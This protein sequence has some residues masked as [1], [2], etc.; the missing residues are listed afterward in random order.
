M[1]PKSKE[2]IHWPARE[3][4]NSIRH[5]PFDFSVSAAY[6]PWLPSCE[7][8]PPHLSPQVS[9][10]FYS[11]SFPTGRPRQLGSSTCTA[12]TGIIAAHSFDLSVCLSVCLSVFLSVCL[13]VCLSVYCMC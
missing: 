7:G 10:A 2:N 12:K 13:S 8:G 11:V 5:S 6:S 9:G 3:I 4:F 1:D